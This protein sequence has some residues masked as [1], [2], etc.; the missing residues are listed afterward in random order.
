MVSKCCSPHT[1]L[2]VLLVL[3]RFSSFILSA[4]TSK[5]PCSYPGAPL[6]LRKLQAGD[7]RYVDKSF[8]P[9]FSLATV[10]TISPSTFAS[11]EAQTL[12]KL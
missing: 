11:G 8:L 6:R 2:L 4:F 3:G 5:L 7:H 1:R 12:T 10:K 9:I